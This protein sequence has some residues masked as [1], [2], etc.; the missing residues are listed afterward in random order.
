VLRL[1]QDTKNWE[2]AMKEKKK[3]LLGLKIIGCVDLFFGAFLLFAF[4]FSLFMGG[5]YFVNNIWEGLLLAAIVVLIVFSI[6]RTG[7]R[8]IR[9]RS[10]LGSAVIAI[11]GLILSFIHFLTARELTVEGVPIWRTPY[12]DVEFLIIALYCTWALIY[13]SRTKVNKQ[14]KQGN[15][16]LEEGVI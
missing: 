12:T 16:N 14:F 5:F 11:C 9:L 6:V 10:M 8:V 13:L 15:Q 2:D 1:L 7:L 4:I 3:I